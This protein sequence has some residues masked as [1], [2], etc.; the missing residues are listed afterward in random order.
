MKRHITAVIVTFNRKALLLRCLEAILSQTRP[1]DRI[2]VVDNA[3]GDGTVEALHSAGLL[4][5]EHVELLA[6]E[7]NTGGAGGFAAGMAHAVSNGS[8]WVW[9][10]DDDGVPYAD[11]LERLDEID[12]DECNL[13][14]SVAVSGDRL[15]WPMVPIGG[16]SADTIWLTAEL[17]AVQS[18]QFIPFLGLMVSRAI[19]Q[20]IG[21]PDAGFF[22]AADDVDYCF[23]ARRLG[24]EIL[25]IGPSRIEHPASER[26]RI[27]LPGRPFYSLRLAPWKRYYDVRNRILVARTHYG[28]ATYYQTIP[29][30]FLRLWGAMVHERH[31]LQQLWAFFAGM[32]DGLLGRK[33]R[34]HEKWGIR[35]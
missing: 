29:A 24:A 14:G 9:I 33:G 22:L 17:K 12:L 26:Y 13:Y 10:M 16:R 11:A 35:P 28:L 1:P 19:T 6:L 21:V 2:L 20:R 7:D 31:R 15:S 3:S 4:A 30:S 5:H 23:R 18:V 25:L 34:R 27:W 8:D 32:I